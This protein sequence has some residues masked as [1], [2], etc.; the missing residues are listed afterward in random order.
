M[1]VISCVIIPRTT[2]LRL[3]DGF[4]NHGRSR[5]DNSAQ[6]D[7]VRCLQRRLKDLGY[8]ID[9]DGFFGQQ[10]DAV[11]REF[12][13][14][15]RITIDG[16]VGP[17]TWGA[18]EAASMTEQMHPTKE[19]FYPP[20]HPSLKRQLAISVDFAEMA[21]QSFERHKSDIPDVSYIAGLISREC[22][23]GM[24]LQPRSPGGTGD[25]TPRT[26]RRAGRTGPFPPD[27]LGYGR[28]LMQ[29]DYDWHEFARTGPWQDPEKNIEYGCRV[30]KDAFRYFGNMGMR[31]YKLD[32]A[33]IAAY[34]A[35]VGAVDRALRRGD[36]PDEVTTGRDFA[37]DTLAR[38]AWFRRTSHEWKML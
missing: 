7:A 2:I 26:S 4:A 16:V 34:N 33:A 32:I 18:I 15:S 21:R 25:F 29:I 20:S 3:G 38:S 19:I 28:G 1:N 11:V 17:Q 30:L 24:T 13:G 31:G 23:W 27:E 36:D 22:A 10:T 9:V 8:S 6:R 5:E 12:Q 14:D 37:Q 35:G